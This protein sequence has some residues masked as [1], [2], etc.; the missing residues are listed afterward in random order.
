M[1]WHQHWNE[2]IEILMGGNFLGT[3][4]ALVLIGLRLATHFQ[5]LCG[6][7][8]SVLMC[9]VEGHTVENPSHYCPV[10]GISDEFFIFSENSQG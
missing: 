4:L 10:S 8:E 1:Q 9:W 2:T 3:V 5:N 6:L 7:W